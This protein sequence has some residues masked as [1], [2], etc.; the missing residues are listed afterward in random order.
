MKFYMAASF[1]RGDETRRLAV[2]LCEEIAGLECIS[3]WLEDHEN[4]NE[5]LSLIDPK[6][7]GKEKA[8]RDINDILCSDFVVQ[9]TGDNL[10]KGGRHVECGIALAADVPVFLLGPLEGIFHLLCWHCNTT[11][12]LITAIRAFQADS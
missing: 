3:S 2:Y 8:E 12:N 5:M 4:S 9:I 1:V 11:E 7:N 10:S 6:L